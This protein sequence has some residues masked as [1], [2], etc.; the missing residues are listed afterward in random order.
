MEPARALYTLLGSAALP[1]LPLRLWWRGRREPRY[2]ERIG[3]RFGRYR[4]LPLDAIPDDY[5]AWLRS[6]DN[7][8]EPLR[9][10]SPILDIQQMNHQY[11]YSR[12]F[13]S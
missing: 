3:E 10:F 8:R 1:L 9:S 5:L 13:R 12:L 11:L 6:L 4:G 7:V 2:R